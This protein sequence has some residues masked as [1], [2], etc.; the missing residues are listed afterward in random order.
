MT[1]DGSYAKSPPTPPEGGMGTLENP[2]VRTLSS[3]MPIHIKN[4]ELQK[5]I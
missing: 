1:R 5:L 4:S 3:M 2:E